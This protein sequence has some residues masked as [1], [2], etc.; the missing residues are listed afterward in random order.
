MVPIISS[1]R[2]LNS[3][4]CILRIIGDSPH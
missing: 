3:S 4:Y 1:I 2:V